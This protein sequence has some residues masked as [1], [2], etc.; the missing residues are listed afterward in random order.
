VEDTGK[1]IDVEV[2]SSTYSQG[3]V[4]LKDIEKRLKLDGGNDSSKL[5]C[6]GVS[7]GMQASDVVAIFK[8]LVPTHGV[9]THIIQ[10]MGTV[11]ASRK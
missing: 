1:G 11:K 3:Y 8:C 2:L 9:I 6:V 5:N 4:N 10:E 7:G